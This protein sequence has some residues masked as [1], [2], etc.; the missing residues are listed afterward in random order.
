MVGTTPAMVTK[1]TT[2]D[3]EQG[4]GSSGFGLAEVD[5]PTLSGKAVLERSI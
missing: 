1:T 4:A 2:S 5:N 3:T